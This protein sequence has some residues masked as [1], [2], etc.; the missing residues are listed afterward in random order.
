MSTEYQ[1]RT[2]QCIPKSFECDKH[3]DCH[4]GSDEVGCLEPVV[5]QP[6]PPFVNLNPGDTFNISCRAVGTPIPLIS[7]RLNWGPIPEKCVTSSHG[8]YGILTCDNVEVRDSGAYSCELINSM[9]TTFVTPDTILTVSGNGSVCQNGY[10]NDKAVRPEECINC[11]CFGVSTQCHSAD[12]FTY[13]LPP[14]VTSLTVA[15]VVGPWT[16]QSQVQVGPFDKHDLIATR[17]GVQFRLDE[18]PLSGELPYYSLPPDY[19]GNQLKSYGGFFR[20]DVEYIGRGRI[21]DAP[22]LILRVS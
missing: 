19:M 18:L 9:G 15:G 6:P 22:D 5:S 13:A 16:G 10:F 17:H 1:C 14:P 11:F 7:W 2:G 21:N 20:Y 4:D 8:G 12:L 3:T